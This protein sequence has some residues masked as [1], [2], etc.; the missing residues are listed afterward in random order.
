MDKTELRNDE[1]TEVAAWID[2]FIGN[3]ETFK[4]LQEI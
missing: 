2:N 1:K 4:R 3:G